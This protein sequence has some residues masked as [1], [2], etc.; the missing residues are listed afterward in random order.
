MPTTKEGLRGWVGHSSREQQGAPNHK[1]E[2]I[3]LLRER[4]S[5]A[6]IS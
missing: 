5:D 1:L 6:E 3:A 2:Q 4:F